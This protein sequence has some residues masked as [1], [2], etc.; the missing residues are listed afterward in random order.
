MELCHGTDVT[1][2][3]LSPISASAGAPV[4][5][6][7]VAATKRQGAVQ[8]SFDAHFKMSAIPSASP[9][10]PS[11]RSAWPPGKKMPASEAEM[12]HKSP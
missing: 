2:R 11:S 1:I 3:S 5:K 7:P 8:K 12:F 4:G 6:L 9:R 10:G